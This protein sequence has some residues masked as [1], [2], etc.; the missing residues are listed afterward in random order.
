MMFRFVGE[1]SVD[2]KS[3]ISRANEFLSLAPNLAIWI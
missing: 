1:D 3:R 2:L